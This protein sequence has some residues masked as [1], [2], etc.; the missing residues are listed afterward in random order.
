MR[1]ILLFI[2]TLLT[3]LSAQAE[4]RETTLKNIPYI[5]SSTLKKQQ[6]DLYLPAQKT[7]NAPVHIFI[8]GGGWN[9]GDKKTVKAKEAK[10]YTDKGIIVVAPNYRLS[11][12]V[13]H[14]AHVQDIAA[15]ISW[16]HKNISKYGGNP[17]NM[18]LSGHSAGA[19]LVA[20]LGTDAKYLAHHKL[21]LN[22]FKAIIPIDTASFDLSLPEK[23][24]LVKRWKK[25]AFGTNIKNLKNASPLHQNIKQELSPFTITVTSKRPDAIASSQALA[26]KINQSGGNAKLII[27]K[28][29]SHKQMKQTLFT[30][31]SETFNHVMDYLKN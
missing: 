13:Q 3:P 10:V 17:K 21:P 7:K 31:N 30:H 9:I 4:P 27:I 28:D 6:L 29:L 20:L 22:M 12:D 15:A 5:E 25:R 11:P 14:P 26:K 18:V 23:K 1:Y 8:H 16:V 2:L 19:H 24:R